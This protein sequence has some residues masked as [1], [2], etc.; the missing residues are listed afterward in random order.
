MQRI[1]H[2]EIVNRPVRMV[3]NQ[4]T[5]S[6]EFPRFMEGVKSV[7]QI[8]DTHQEWHA[9]IGG[10]EVRWQAEIIDQVPDQRIV[11]QS[12]TGRRNGG[13]VEFREI[14][15]DQTEVKLVMEYEPEGA[16]EKAGDAVGVADSRVKGDLKRFKQ[17]VESA[18]AETGAWRGEVHRGQTQGP[19][20]SGIR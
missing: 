8:D 9:E 18:P 10:K 4:W 6:E 5:Q 1:E 15:A 13:K 14:G 17:F 11:W 12:I 7:R 3:Y 19:G 16:I 2:S 20:S